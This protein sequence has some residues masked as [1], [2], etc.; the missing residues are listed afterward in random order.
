MTVVNE[1]QLGLRERKRRATENAIETAA[2]GIALAEGPDVVT[3]ERICEQAFVSR[4]TFFNYFPTRD[5][6]IYGRPIEL[7]PS[8]RVDELLNE[9]AHALPIGVG[10][11]V[12][13]GMGVDHINA[14]VARAR[15]ELARRYPEH[16]TWLDWE[17]AGAGSG[18]ARWSPTGSRGTP[19]TSGSA[20]RTPTPRR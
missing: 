14:D 11:A 4:S 2:V 5:S 18:F 3:V 1:R 12:L 9:W 20:T 10:L 19:S 16:M 6:A 7:Q 17:V 13:E 15:L 8:E